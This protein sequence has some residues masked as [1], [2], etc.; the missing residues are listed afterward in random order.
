[1]SGEDW[2]RI[3]EAA[4]VLHDLPMF[5]VDSGNVTILDIRASHAIFATIEAAL[6]SCRT[7]QPVDV[8]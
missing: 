3:A 6:E 7:G 8:K 2:A 5:I 1:M 4:E